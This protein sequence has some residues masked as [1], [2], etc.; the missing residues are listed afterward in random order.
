[1]SDYCVNSI[2]L[3]KDANV[4]VHSVGVPKRFHVYKYHPLPEESGLV[5]TEAKVKKLVLTHFYP[6]MDKINYLVDVRKKY[7]GQIII[8]HDLM[9]IEI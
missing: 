2:K 5:A 3:A 9:K 4:L 1:M 8:A 7:K 6:V